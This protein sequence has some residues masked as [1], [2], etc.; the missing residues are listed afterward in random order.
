MLI[1]SVLYRRV[2]YI[3]QNPLVISSSTRIDSALLR[4]GGYRKISNEVFLATQLSAAW[5]RR[6]CGVAVAEVEEI[7]VEKLITPR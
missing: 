6:G 5:P 4:D 7:E 3:V 2:T 1:L